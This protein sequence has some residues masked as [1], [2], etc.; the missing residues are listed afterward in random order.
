[1]LDT[2]KSGSS[3]L[4]GGFAIK[5]YSPGIFKVTVSPYF[6]HFKKPTIWLAVP[7]QLPEHRDD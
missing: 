1:M 3:P 6:M 4:E 7:R 2:A 5:K